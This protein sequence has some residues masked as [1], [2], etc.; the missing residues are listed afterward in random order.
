MQQKEEIEVF[1]KRWSDA[2]SQYRQGQEL[3]YTY[4]R[5]IDILREKL[6]GI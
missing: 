2:D 1:R 6:A 4:Q 5:E 3:T